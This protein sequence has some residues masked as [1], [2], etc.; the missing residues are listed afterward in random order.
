MTVVKGD[1]REWAVGDKLASG[2]FGAIYLARSD[3]LDAVIKLVP[4]DPG[5]DREFLIAELSGVR[6]VLPLLDTGQTDDEWA[7]V[8]PRAEESLRQHLEDQANR[9]LDV[10]TAL[11]IMIDV[12]E[13]LVDLDAK[14]VVHRDLKPENVLR[15]NGRWCLIDFGIARYA[16]AATATN[17]RKDSMT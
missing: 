1:G 16:E 17:T 9:P 13:A 12:A 15:Y 2:G 3:D 7:L 14:R 6:N 10:D 11:S 4:K 8:M 5:A